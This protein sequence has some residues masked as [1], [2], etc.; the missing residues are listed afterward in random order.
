MFTIVWCHD[1][2]EEALYPRAENLLRRALALNTLILCKD[3]EICILKELHEVGVLSHAYIF[4][5]WLILSLII[6][7]LVHVLDLWTI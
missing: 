7:L 4:Y 2:R 3:S 5:Y 6:R 1:S